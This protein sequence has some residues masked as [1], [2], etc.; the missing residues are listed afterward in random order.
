MDVKSRS[1]LV[2]CQVPRDL[3]SLA[4][5]LNSAMSDPTVE[6]LRRLVDTIDG[7]RAA[8]A[9]T[10]HSSE[11]TIYQIL[12]GVPLKSGKPRV[13]GRDLRERLDRHYPNWLDT[14]TQDGPR[15]ALPLVPPMPPTLAQ[16]VDRLAELLAPLGDEARERA[17]LRL[18][19][20]AR[21]PD[22]ADARA[23]LQAELVAPL[24]RQLPPGMAETQDFAGN[25]PASYQGE[26]NNETERRPTRAGQR[27]PHR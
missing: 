11:Q 21:A 23:K 14:P 25:P 5:C 3:N 6:A 22:S 13:V 4:S 15:T 20:L 16:V 12:R 26:P 1:E 2:T 18:Q 7:G 9:S 27:D 24:Q 17:V 10:I 8:L 19:T